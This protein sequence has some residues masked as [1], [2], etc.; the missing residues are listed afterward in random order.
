MSSL[1]NQTQNN[2][3]MIFAAA[4]FNSKLKS[5]VLHLSI[6]FLPF[7]QFMNGLACVIKMYHYKLI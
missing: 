5:Q 4:D 6:F 2:P 1:N 7:Y 3:R